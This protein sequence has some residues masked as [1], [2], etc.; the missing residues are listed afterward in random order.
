MTPEST[1]PEQQILPP[2]TV[3]TLVNGGSGLARYEGCVVFVP[4]TAAGDLV[5]AGVVRRKKKYL[6]AQL[7]EVLQPG[8]GRRVPPC[9]VAGECGGCQ[10][11]HLSYN[12]QLA[13]KEKLFTETLSHQLLSD[14]CAF[15]PIIPSSNE[16][17]YRSRVQIKC[18]NCA[19]GFVTGYYRSRSRYVVNIDSCPIMDHRLNNLLAELKSFFNGSVFADQIPQIDLSI[20]DNGKSAA[21]IHYLGPKRKR[22]IERLSDAGI[23][24]DILVQFGTKK[25]LQSVSG[26]GIL[27]IRVDI[28]QLS[29]NYRV[30]SFAQINLEQN[31]ALVDILTSIFPWNKTH[32]VLELYCGMGNLSFPIARRV[33][34]LHGIE[35]S[36]LS[37]A[38][39]RRNIMTTGITN[40]EFIAASAE[41]VL[42]CQ[43]KEGQYDVVILDPPR[44]GAYS[45]VKW[46]ARVGIPHIFY[47]SCDPQTLARDLQLLVH[48]DYRI[49]ASQ[50]L[51]M[52]PQTYHCE[53]ITYLQKN[54]VSIAGAGSPAWC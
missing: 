20:D 32:R 48:A 38:M 25:S 52:F 7:V 40:L 5:R 22:L 15:K 3:E 14:R 9:P 11:Q 33:R 4:H 39:A 41:N 34:Y 16:W 10:W 24:A 50:P 26:D 12:E 1:L 37:I 44:V 53:S 45:V 18:Y 19:E 31:K 8:P 42:S 29:L 17:Y 13:W 36:E 47:V 35:E 54:T 27:A 23:D 46:L 28:P 2:L 30:G 51:D 21:V 43:I 6:E 49:V